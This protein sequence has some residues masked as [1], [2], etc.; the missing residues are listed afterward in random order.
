MS[1]PIVFAPLALAAAAFAWLRAPGSTR[2]RAPADLRERDGQLAPDYA[3][4]RDTIEN[5]GDG[6]AGFD[7][8][9]RMVLCNRR[10]LEL[11]DL[12]GGSG[13]ATNLRDILARQASRGDFGPGDPALQVGERVAAFYGDAPAGTD[14]F[15][16]GGRTLQV[17]RQPMQGGIVLAV[18]SDI[19]DRKAAEDRLTR[20][21]AD[22]E[23]GNRAK[24]EFLANMSHELRTPLN[25][26]IGFSE[27]ISTQMLGPIGDPKYL[28]YVNDI[29]ASGM[30][31]LAIVSDVLDMSKIEAGKLELR[32]APVAVGAVVAEAIR[33]VDARARSRAIRIEAGPAIDDMVVVAD[34]RAFL[35]ITLNLLSNAVKFSPDDSEIAI[36]ARAEYDGSFVFEIEDH[37]IGMSAD[38]LERA[39]QPFG[40]VDTPATRSQSGTG[41]GLPITKGL[42]EA[43]GGRIEIATGLGRG[44]T[45]RVVLPRAASAA[46]AAPSPSP[47]APALRLVGDERAVA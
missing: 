14:R 18:Y 10:L 11:L 28:E 34:E 35:Q 38:G 41:L 12:P 16:V 33:M 37:G 9:G 32:C 3:L 24:S 6:V 4:L 17:K 47:A 5:L 46:E 30:H 19:T 1:W 15:A 44:T 20:A 2:R 25:A 23:L 27:V 40:Q 36:R 39:M 7:R 8:S 13:P 31:L 22:A 29:H 45:V 21:W 26:I 43:H 42:V